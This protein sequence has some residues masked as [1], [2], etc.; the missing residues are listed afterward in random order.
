MAG[1]FSFEVHE[2]TGSL[3]TRNGPDSD[4]D[5]LNWSV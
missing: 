3:R 5:F 4:N 2:I 1:R